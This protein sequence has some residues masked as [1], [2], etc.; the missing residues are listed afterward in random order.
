MKGDRKQA[1]AGG[2]VTFSCVGV[3]LGGFPI[4]LWF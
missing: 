4:G 3:L 2:E 1:D